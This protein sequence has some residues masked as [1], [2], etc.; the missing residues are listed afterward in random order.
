MNPIN[1]FLLGDVMP[2]KKQ[3]MLAPT[4]SLAPEL[5]LMN[6]GEF[7][8][9]LASDEVVSLT[10]AQQLVAQPRSS[11]DC[12]YVEFE[13]QYYSIFCFNKSLQLQSSMNVEHSTIVLFNTQNILFGICCHELTKQHAA[14]L[15]LHAVPPSMR[16]RKQPFTE[17]TIIDNRAVGLSSGAALVALLRLRGAK[18]ISQPGSVSALLGAG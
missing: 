13:Q 10:S 12:G 3:L 8:I 9:L 16:S 14:A 7:S 18:L 1:D 5:V 4:S 2:D 6:C 11:F 17:F 15:T